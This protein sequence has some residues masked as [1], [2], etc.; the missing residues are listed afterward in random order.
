MKTEYMLKLSDYGWLQK[1]GCTAPKNTKKKWQK[2]YQ[3]SCSVLSTW[4]KHTIYFRPQNIVP[5][6]RQKCPFLAFNLSYKMLIFLGTWRCFICKSLQDTQNWLPSKIENWT[7]TYG[8]I[9]CE[10]L[11]GTQN[12]VPFKIYPQLSQITNFNLPPSLENEGM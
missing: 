9:P 1:G 8:C 6:T 7:W 12:Q 10:I 2:T 3:N 11:H 4:W 5:T